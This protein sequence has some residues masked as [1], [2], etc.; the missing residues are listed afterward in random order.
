MFSCAVFVYVPNETFFT[1]ILRVLWEF[2][3]EK[4]NLLL[5]ILFLDIRKNPALT[6]DKQALFP[7][8]PGL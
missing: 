2:C 8:S 3:G 5:Q 1:E 6:N 7:G 4:N